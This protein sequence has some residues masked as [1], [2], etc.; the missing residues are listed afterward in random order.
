MILFNIQNNLIIYL[1]FQAEN[2]CDVF[3]DKATTYK[4]SEAYE[5]MEEAWDEIAQKELD[6][7][8]MQSPYVGV[9]MDETTDIAVN[10]KLI[11][12]F[13]IEEMVNQELYLVV[14]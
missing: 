12:Y 3:K 11:I 6:R 1:F 4:H 8:I 10:K 7:L 13:K 2:G 14:M 9:M 5:D